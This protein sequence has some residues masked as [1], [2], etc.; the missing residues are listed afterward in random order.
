M[1]GCSWKVIASRKRVT[2]LARAAGERE[3]GYPS[4]MPTR[5]ARPSR[6]PAEAPMPKVLSAYMLLWTCTNLLRIS[7]GFNQGTG[8]VG[9]TLDAGSAINSIIL[10]ALVLLAGVCPSRCAGALPFAALLLRALTNIAK[11]S[12]MSNSQMWATQMDAALAL[13]LGTRVASRDASW[14]SPLSAEDERAIVG[15]SARTIRWQL[16]IFYFA[17]GFVSTPCRRAPKRA[18]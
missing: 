17:S 3:G 8:L 10:P 11:G 6:P 12:M 13:A 15:A 9:S 5:A 16:A 18:E 4:G 14:R 2:T 7:I 1:H